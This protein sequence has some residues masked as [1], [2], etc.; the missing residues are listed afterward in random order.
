MK[1]KKQL[2]FIIEAKILNFKKIKTSKINTNTTNSTHQINT[3]NSNI[4]SRNKFNNYF[5]NTYSKSI[6]DNNNNQTTFIQ[7]N[8]NINY[9]V[10]T[11]KQIF[12]IQN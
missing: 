12:Y 7:N 1:V 4:Y 5:L 10:I 3:S 9:L 8:T 2:I 11:Q 6:T